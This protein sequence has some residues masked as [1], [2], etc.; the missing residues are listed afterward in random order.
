[1]RQDM[2]QFT[3]SFPGKYFTARKQPQATLFGLK[4]IVQARSIDNVN[5]KT[6][7]H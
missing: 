5:E 7:T 6:D 2:R 4:K 3:K 1:M